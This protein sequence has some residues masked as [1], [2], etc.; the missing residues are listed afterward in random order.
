MELGLREKVVLITGGAEGIGA[1]ISRACLEEGAIPCIVTRD[2]EAVHVPEEDQH[3][4]VG[5][6]A[7]LWFSTA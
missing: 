3:G 5:T 2:S 4:G 7:A 6:G 1:A